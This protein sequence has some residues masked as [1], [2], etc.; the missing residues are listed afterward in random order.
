MRKEGSMTITNEEQIQQVA[1][2]LSDAVNIMG[3]GE[4]E[5]A[6]A[7]LSDH[8]TL[9]QRKAVVFL[10]FFRQLAEDAE[11]GFTDERDEAAGRLAIV[12]R[13]AADAAGF[14]D[15]LPFI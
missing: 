15:D 13:D 5:L 2:A 4:A 6:T 14:G 12:I 3:R 11:K 10:S 8:R 7:L 1:K 9:I